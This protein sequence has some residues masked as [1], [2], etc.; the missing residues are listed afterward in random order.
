M[1]ETTRKI[2]TF[3]VPSPIGGIPVGTYEGYVEHAIIRLHGHVKTPPQLMR[4]MLHL[5]RRQHPECF[6][7]N[8]SMIA[9]DVDVTQHIRNGGISYR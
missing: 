7:L 4:A 8:N 9:M 1:T 6:S 5:D 2:V 3:D